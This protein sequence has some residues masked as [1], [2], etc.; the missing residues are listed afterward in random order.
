MPSV[1]SIAAGKAAVSQFDTDGDG[2]IRGDE[3]AKVPSLKHALDRV[4]ANGDGAVSAEEIANRVGQWE[5]MQTGRMAVTCMIT[6]D[7][8]PVHGATVKYVP[9]AFLGSSLQTATGV[10]DEN[11]LASVS[12]PTSGNLPPGVAPGFYRVEITMEGEV[13]PA[14][15]NTGTTLGRE[16]AVDAEGMAQ[17]THKVT[18]FQL[19]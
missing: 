11:G 18:S 7:G 2:T 17:M 15:Y 1:D 19:D 14:K 12:A 6:K 9:E 10:T 3:L 13:I 16:V 8:Q 5:T 4:D